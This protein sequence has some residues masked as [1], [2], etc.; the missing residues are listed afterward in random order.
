LAIINGILI[1]YGM[2]NFYSLLALNVLMMIRHKS[3][4]TIL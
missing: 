2:I 1:E 3:S 4:Q